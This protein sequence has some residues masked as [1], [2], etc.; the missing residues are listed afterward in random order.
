MA[1]VIYLPKGGRGDLGE[2]LGSATGKVVGAKFKN[3]QA[4]QRS[5]Q[6]SELFQ[7]L[8]TGGQ[9]GD[10]QAK[11]SIASGAIVDPTDIIRLVGILRQREQDKKG[12]L[13]KIPAFDNKGQPTAYAATLEDVKSG[14]AELDANERGLTLSG[15]KRTGGSPTD[16]QISIGDYLKS[17]NLES[18][19]KTRT[20]ARQFLFNRHKASDIIN[21][22]FGKKF[23]T[24]WVIEPG[25]KQQMAAYA[26]DLV[27]TLIVDEGL[28]SQQ[29]G[30]EATRRARLE[31]EEPA[32]EN[33]ILDVEEGGEDIFDLIRKMIPGS[34]EANKE[35][36][37]EQ[38]TTPTDQKAVDTLGT[39]N[40]VEVGIPRD[41]SLSPA[42]AAEYISKN[43]DISIEDARSF[44]LGLEP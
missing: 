8:Q 12:G 23:G 24:D 41:T 31:F 20:Q 26:E 44:V 4:Q 14:K 35:T 42:Q 6:L 18:S 21:A 30:T 38:E 3:D 13:T 34:N 29:A 7:G 1:T 27:E 40:G 11:K 33:E 5:Q 25:V 15:Q 17:K 37:L 28:T 43:Y 9:E 22:Q 32:E 19:S 36:T 39:L 10:T 2:V 16:K